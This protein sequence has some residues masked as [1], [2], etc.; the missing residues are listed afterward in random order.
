[1]RNAEIW[2]WKTRIGFIE[3]NDND[4]VRFEYDDDF[5]RSGIEISPIMMPLSRVIYSFPE[6]PYNSF[7]G[8]PGLVSDSLPDRFGNA[9]IEDW[10]T[11]QGR[12]LESFNVIDRLCYI[13]TRGM[14]ALEYKPQTSENYSEQVDIDLL[15]NL[16]NEVLKDRRD[17]SVDSSKNE[18]MTQLFN[19]GSSAGGARAKAIIAWNKKTGEIRSGQIDAGE[20][21]QYYIIKF[22][23]VDGNGDHGL[24]DSK[25]YTNIEYAYY[26][27]S[28]AAGIDMM[29]CE[30]YKENGRNHFLTKRF[31]RTH[32]GKIHSQTF[33]AL[34]HLDYNTPRI[35]GYEYL[36]ETC[37]KIGIKQHQI[38]QL[39]KRMVFNVLAVNNDDHVKNFSFLMNRNGEWSL[40]PAYDMTF[41]YKEDNI[42][43]REHQMLVNGKSRNISK[44]DLLISGKNMGISKKR[45][46]LI[47]EEVSYAIDKWEDFAREAEVWEDN[48]RYIKG[49]INKVKMLF[50]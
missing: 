9:V 23:G 11:R 12:S 2:M 41:A 48:I 29:P 37:R 28:T 38:E 14:G 35:T 24:S 43:L 39:Y 21:F 3:I 49:M 13:G 36:A 4:I 32:E 22:D 8:L 25:G 15:V 1:M 42:W 5:T 33:G 19:V 17:L 18:A 30:L 45:C 26:L 31:D 27:M 34:C 50:S 6:L 7:K 16:A 44:E 10:L 47:I 46:N 40:S 20:G